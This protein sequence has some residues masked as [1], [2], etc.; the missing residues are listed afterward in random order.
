MI[1][2]EYTNILIINRKHKAKEI[3]GKTVFIKG[4][5][6][7]FYLVTGRTQNGYAILDENFKQDVNCLVVVELES[8]G[9]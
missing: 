9:S 4:N 1:T 3:V 8:V 2:D 6:D 5:K 7:K